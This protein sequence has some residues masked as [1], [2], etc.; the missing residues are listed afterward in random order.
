MNNQQQASPLFSVI[1]PT[2]NRAHLLPR[3]IKSVLNQNC[4]EWELIVVD[5]GSEDNTRELVA[6]YEDKRVKYVYQEHQ[7]RSTA[8]NTGI[9]AAKGQYICFLDDDDYFLDIHLTMLEQAIIE[10]DYHVAIFR[11]GMIILH[12]KKKQRSK[13][14]NEAKHKNPVFFFLKNMAGIHTLCFHKHILTHH[15]FDIRWYHYQDTHLLIRG[16]L[17]YPFRQIM[18]HTCVYVRHEEMGSYQAF[19][20]ETITH[21]VENNVAAIRNLFEIAG[22]KI[23]RYTTKDI[24]DYLVGEK[25]LGYAVGILERGNIREATTLLKKSLQTGMWFGLWKG[26]MNFAYKFLRTAPRIKEKKYVQT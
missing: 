15:K 1:I 12:K 16:L 11:T 17:D 22:N 5:D 14:Y 19:K 7:E 10:S 24:E 25:Y 23:S 4:P 9:E 21:R 8:R 2:Y 6:R 18:A 3:A 20:N 26:Y 13:Y